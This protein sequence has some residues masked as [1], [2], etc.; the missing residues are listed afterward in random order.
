MRIVATVLL[1]V[2]VFLDMVS[3]S[4]KREEVRPSHKEALQN[5]RFL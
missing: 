5:E 4:E 2:V 1:V 3:E